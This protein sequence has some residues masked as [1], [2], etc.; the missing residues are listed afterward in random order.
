M[1]VDDLIY[2]L[3]RTPDEHAKKSGLG[4]I[5]TAIKRQNCDVFKCKT[6]NR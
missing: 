3:F 5:F 2:F 4:E 1:I 6:V